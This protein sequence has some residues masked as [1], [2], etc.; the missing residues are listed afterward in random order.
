MKSFGGKAMQ[1]LAYRIGVLLSSYSQA[2]N[3]QNKTTGSLFQ[4]KTKAKHLT[5]DQISISGS[6]IKTSYVVTGMHYIHQNAWKAGL[7]DKIEDWDYSSFPDYIGKR[8][9][10]LCNKELAYMLTGYDAAHFYEDSY[11][12][13]EPGLV[14]GIF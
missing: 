9:G 2:I 4:Q 13:L 14:N 12:I 10:E 3:K 11:G 8:N 1:E 6:T 5:T 7:V